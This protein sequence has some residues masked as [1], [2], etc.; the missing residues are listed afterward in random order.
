MWEKYEQNVLSYE[1]E[2]ELLSVAWRWLGE[3]KVHC[4]ARYDF[5]DKTDK[6]LTKLIWSLLDECD[7][8]IG[9]NSDDFDIRKSKAKFIEH[10]MK[11][12]SPFKQIDTKKI[13]KSQFKFNSNSLNDLGKTLKLGQKV[14][15]TGFQL[16]LD[17]MANKKSAWALM[18]RYNRQDVVLLEKV[19]ERLRPW[20]NSGV[21]VSA[22]MGGG[23]CPSCGSH[24][25]MY[26]GVDKFNHNKKRLS[27]RYCNRWFYAKLTKKEKK[28]R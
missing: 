4:K 3:K 5:K 27:C 22:L 9:H 6:S 13:A 1:K 21:D 8:A 20:I 24:E 2:W 16:W 15:H 10:N 28:N 12:P 7:I 26:R 23:G 19:Y 14:Q 18:K 25:I 11:P 17:C